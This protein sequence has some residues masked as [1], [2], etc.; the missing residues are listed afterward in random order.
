MIWFTINKDGKITQAKL[1]SL[2]GLTG[3]VGFYLN[4]G[5]T[6]EMPHDEAPTEDM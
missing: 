1:I 6:L 3:P 5:G 2:G 4:V